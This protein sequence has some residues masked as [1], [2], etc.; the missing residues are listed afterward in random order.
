MPFHFV[1]RHTLFHRTS[2]ARPQLSLDAV[3][4]Q[5]VIHHPVFPRKWSVVL[6]LTAVAAA[7]RAPEQSLLGRVSTIV[8]AQEV[9]PTC[10]SPIVAKEVSA[11]ENKDLGIGG[12]LDGANVVV[13]ELHGMALLG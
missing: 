1:P 3:N 6:A 2:H 9:G 12:R 10:E 13:N 7:D 4:L 8:V 11:A 5:S